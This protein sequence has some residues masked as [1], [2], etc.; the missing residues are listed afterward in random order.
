[1][2]KSFAIAFPN[3]QKKNI[4]YQ[5]KQSGNML[6][7]LEQLLHFTLVRLLVLIWLT[8]EEQIGQ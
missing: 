7:V 1:M 3:R 8:T 4:D 5:Q 2:L 6:V